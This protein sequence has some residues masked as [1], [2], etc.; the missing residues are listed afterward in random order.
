MRSA[1]RYYLHIGLHDYAHRLLLRSQLLLGDPWIQASEIAVSSVLGKTSKLFK[2]IDRNLQELPE[3]ALNFSELGS[4]IATV[5][6]NTGG[7]KKAKKLFAKSLINPNDN[8]VAQAEWA[9][10]RLGLVV[11]DKAL[12]VPLSFEANSGHSY[13]TLEIDDAIAQGEKWL[14][15]EPFAS[16]PVG[17]LGYLHSLNDDFEK[18]TKYHQKVVQ[19]EADATT[20][21]W[22]N[23]NFSKIESGALEE[24]SIELIKLSQSSDTAGNRAHLLANAGALSYATGDIDSGR[25]LYRRAIDIAKARSE[26]STEAL[27]SAFFA[28]AAVKYGDSKRDDIVAEVI[29]QSTLNVN[30]GAT[31]VISKLVDKTSRQKLEASAMKK[32][33]K[34][35]LS[36]DSISNTLTI[37]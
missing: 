28:R 27:V 4:A 31:F 33:A 37:I 17:W 13:R 35:R 23:L 14:I 10:R 19:I 32:V 24:A 7:D 34:Q 5:H 1:V 30:P 22:L 15:D 8:T 26:T 12:K 6:F 29:K 36:W 3:L 16:R 18:A 9:A 21:D 25:Q 2:G 11:T 20:A